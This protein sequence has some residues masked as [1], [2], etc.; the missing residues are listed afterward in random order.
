M[1]KHPWHTI[2]ETMNE[3][4]DIRENEDDLRPIEL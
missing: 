3:I 4:D 1:D 2:P